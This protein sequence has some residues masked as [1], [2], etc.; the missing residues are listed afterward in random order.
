[1]IFRVLDTKEIKDEILGKVAEGK[2][3]VTQLAEQY[4]I[5]DKTMGLGYFRSN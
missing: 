4:A 1:M 3:K 5:S 2:F